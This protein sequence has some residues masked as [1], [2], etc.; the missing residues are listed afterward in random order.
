MRKSNKANSDRTSRIRCKLIFFLSNWMGSKHHSRNLCSLCLLVF[1]SNKNNFCPVSLFPA[2][3]FLSDLQRQPTL[4]D[5]NNMAAECGLLGWWGGQSASKQ[6]SNPA[7]Q[8][9]EKDVEWNRLRKLPRDK[10]PTIWSIRSFPFKCPVF[11]RLG[12]LSNC[13]TR[14]RKGSGSF[15]GERVWV[16]NGLALSLCPCD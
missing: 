15:G 9:V 2:D 12:S 7:S 13:C 11:L 14:S 5:W 10:W 8:Q 16:K 4:A 6:A 1:L 3:I